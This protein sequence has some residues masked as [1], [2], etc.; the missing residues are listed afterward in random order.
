VARVLIVD[1]AEP[2]RDLCSRMLGGRGHEIFLA[3]S[4]AE[5]VA[6]YE[7]ERP[8][9]VL[10]DVSMPDMDGLATLEAIRTIDPSARVAMLT[11]TRDESAVRRAIQLGASDYIVKP[12]QGRR[13]AEAIERMTAAP[14]EDA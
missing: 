12:F 14:D 1:D 7:Q 2:V 10:L 6:I 5:G 8:D 13:L 11:G 4:G 9:A 3:A